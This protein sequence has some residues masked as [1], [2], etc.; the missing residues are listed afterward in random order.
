MYSLVAENQYGN[1]LQLT[2]N[3]NY[4]ILSITGLTPASATINTDVVATADGEIFNSSRVNMRNIVITISYRR[5]VETNRIALYQF[6]KTKQYVKLYYTNNHRN[7]YIEGYVET[8]EGD[9]FRNGQQAQ[10]SILC[11]Q[12]YFKDIEDIATDFVSVVNAF[13]FPV[14]FPEAGIEFSTVSSYV[15]KVITN[16]GDEETGVIIELHAR[17]TAIN[18]ALYNLTTG[19]QFLIK[20]EMSQG[21]IITINTNSGQKEILLN[22]DGTITNLINKVN[23]GSNWFKLISG[24][25]VFS[26]ACDFGAANLGVIFYTTPLYEGV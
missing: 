17:G 9:L 20:Y 1:T 14:E 10:I 16:I 12:P 6:F 26:Y 25:N 4:D 19:E 3:A 15:E 18:P 5:D 2:G 21:D 22:S 23:R 7:V 11:P 13:E 8:F 24:D